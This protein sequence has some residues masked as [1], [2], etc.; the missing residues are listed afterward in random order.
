MPSSLL[1]LFIQIVW[2]LYILRLV[3]IDQIRLRDHLIDNIW[4]KQ[5]PINFLCCYHCQRGWYE[6][7]KNERYARWPVA[8]SRPWANSNVGVLLFLGWFWKNFAVRYDPL[9]PPNL[10][11]LQ[12]E[13]LKWDPTD[14]FRLM[15][16]KVNA[17]SIKCPMLYKGCEKISRKDKYTIKEP[18][19][20][21]YQT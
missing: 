16:L 7:Y 17:Y 13:I 3:D 2:I 5:M 12:K 20:I 1:E 14:C 19:W 9:Q 15:D 10:F 21:I 6:D 11:Q 8:S 18:K 4:Q